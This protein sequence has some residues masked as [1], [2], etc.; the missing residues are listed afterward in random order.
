MEEEGDEEEAGLTLLGRNTMPSPINT[1]QVAYCPTMELLALGAADE[2]AHVFRLNG[3]R[4]FGVSRKGSPD[5]IIAL[6]WK[7]DG[8]ALAV[9]FGNVVCISSAYTGKVMYEKSYLPSPQI[10]ITCLGWASNAVDA[11]VTNKDT[12]K[13]GPKAALDDFISSYKE[14]NHHP[15]AP[16]LPMEIAFID[17]ASVLPKLSTL[18]IGGSE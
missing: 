14:A 12:A 18:P 1:N 11:P 16:D 17:V 3:Q 7:P 6:K 15:S 8:S 5:K 2:Q 4:V 13:I 9:A 10:P